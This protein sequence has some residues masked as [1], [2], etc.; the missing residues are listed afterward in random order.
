MSEPGEKPPLSDDEE[1]ALRG[2]RMY[3]LAERGLANS[4][5]DN[6]LSDIKHFLTFSDKEYRAI[7]L[8]DITA[9]ISR[10][11]AEG[12]KATSVNRH[13]SSLRV[14]YRYLVGEGD[15]ASSPLELLQ[16]PKLHERLPDYLF[17][18]EVMK[19]IDATRD[20][21]QKLESE[22]TPFRTRF[23]AA[24]D[25]AAI[26]LL[27]ATGLRAGE[28]VGLRFSDIDPDL[29]IIRTVGKRSKERLV[30]FGGYAADMLDYYLGNYRNEVERESPYIF[31]D[32]LGK[33]GVTRQTLWKAVKRYSRL[34]GVEP[35]KPHL[36]RH[37]F[38]THLI[39]A[40]ADLRT[41]QEMLGHASIATTQIYTHLNVRILKEIHKSAHPRG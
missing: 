12:F 28:L 26:A 30:P 41:V 38:A 40:G 15:M 19:V 27:Y 22:D 8:P 16:T 32:H 2:F 10:L 24:R 7:E 5:A 17:F 9:Y 6:Y 36:L 3:L 18:D 39:Q 20:D 21:L 34:A 23:R 33:D 25:N 11:M 35:L 4:T 29:R 37:T 13:S 1:K 14:F 31:V